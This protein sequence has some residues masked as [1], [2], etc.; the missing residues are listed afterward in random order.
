MRFT[1]S[2]AAMSH[3]RPGKTRCHGLVRPGTTGGGGVVAARMQ[4]IVVLL[5]LLF[6]AACEVPYVERATQVNFDPAGEGFWAVPLP[7]EL[8]KQE[9]GSYNLERWPGARPALITMWLRDHRRSAPRRLGRQRWGL[10]HALRHARP[11]FP[12]PRPPARSP[13]TRRCSSSTSTPSR[14]EYGRRFPVDSAFTAE[15]ITYRPASL[16]AVTAGAGLSRAASRRSTRWC[17]STA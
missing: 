1:S 17:C 16:L 14:P 5:S 15:A 3:S 2:A 12:A 7:S 11:R 8:R 4:R 6:L 13:R 10:L 9:D